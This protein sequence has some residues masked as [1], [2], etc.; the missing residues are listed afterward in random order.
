L[1]GVLVVAGVVL[2]AHACRSYARIR[3]IDAEDARQAV[4]WAVLCGFLGAHWVALL[5][6]HPEQVWAEPWSL[7]LVPRGIA[8]T[9]GFLGALVGLL[10]FVRRHPQPVAPLADMLLFGLMIGFPF[11]RLGCALVHDHPGMLADANAWL[12]V[13]PWPCPCTGGGASEACCTE[14]IYRYDLGLIELLGLI[15]L[16]AG[17]R[18]FFPWRRAAAG[19]LSGTVAIAY[20]VGRF[21]LDF[22][23]TADVRY[24]GLTF[25]Q[26]ACIAFVVL[27][28]ITLL[29]VRT[30]GLQ[31]TVSP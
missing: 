9:G 25:A 18:L 21:G 12:A 30:S 28:I 8:S 11:G 13:G 22:L 15:A 3:G 24:A 26:Y 31:T 10:V 16:A 23:R 29:R 6:Y 4:S 17:I 14:P 5:A 7:L 27:G 2:G 19:M 1:F 20:G